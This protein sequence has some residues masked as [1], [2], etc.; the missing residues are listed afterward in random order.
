MIL[1][2]RHQIMEISPGQQDQL[3]RRPAL[4]YI[5]TLGSLP[6]P[7]KMPQIMRTVTLI[8]MRSYPAHKPGLPLH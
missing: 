5:N 3:V 4:H 8:T 7:L 6:D 2:Q 1:G